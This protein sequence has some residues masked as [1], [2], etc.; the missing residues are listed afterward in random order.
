[1]ST[2]KQIQ[3]VAKHFLIAAIWADAPD[4]THPRASH[5]TKQHAQSICEAFIAKHESLF[6]WAMECASEGYG[7]H[8]DAGSP[9]A[10]FGHDFWLTLQGHGT[11]FW[12]RDEL[13]TPHNLLRDNLTRAC[14]DFGK[15]YP[16]FYRGWLYLRHSC[17]GNA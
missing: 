6:A 3:T 17:L 12:D 8:P 15:C 10:A 1:M 9:E 13:N 7:S 14:K 11:G 5:C 16:E 4:G 2:N